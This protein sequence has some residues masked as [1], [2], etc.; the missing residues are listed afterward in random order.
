MGLCWEA[1]LTGNVLPGLTV[2]MRPLWV[3]TGSVTAAVVSTG[4]PVV[5]TTIGVMVVGGATVVAGRVGSTVASGRAGGAVERC[6]TGVVGGVGTV[7]H[8]PFVL[9]GNGPLTHWCGWLATG[10]DKPLYM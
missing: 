7:G 1:N 10:G 5:T 2:V 9:E 3:L 4:A 6:T 8:G